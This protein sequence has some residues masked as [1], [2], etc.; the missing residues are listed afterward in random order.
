MLAGEFFREVF[1][2]A[3]GYVCIAM[4]HRKSGNKD[5]RET[6]YQ[7]PQQLQ[8]MH[9]AIEKSKYDR[10]IYFC[11]QLLTEPKR[12]KTS[13]ATATC[14]WCDLDTCNPDLLL[15]QPSIAIRTSPGRFQAFWRF[16][17]PQAPSVGEDI[18][19]RIAYR[20][21][22]DGADRSGWDLT[23]L[24]RVPGTR[25]FKYGEG[26]LAPPVEVV[27]QNDTRYRTDDFEVYP[28]AEGYEYTTIPMP[29]LLVEDG[30]KI[31]ERF[32]TRISG[33]AFTLFSQPVKEGDRSQALFRLEMLCAEAGMQ[34]EETFQVCR[35]S[36][37]NKWKEEPELLWRDICRA[38]AVHKD[39]QSLQQVRREDVRL[40]TEEERQFIEA[41]PTFIER[42]AAWGRTIG[43]AAHQYHRGAA[44]VALSAVLSGSIY[45]KAKFGKI[46]PN[47][48]LMILADTT[49]TR[50]ST[51][52]NAA[53]DIV[54]EVDETI[55]MATDGSLEG[56]TQALSERTGRTSIF[57][58]DEFTGLLESMMRKDYMAGLPE[59]F[60]ALYDGSTQIRRLRKD[61]IRIKSPRL[62]IFA[63]GIKSR[64][65]SIVTF[66]QV[67][68]GFLPRFI[69][70]TAE[71]D[72]TKMKPLSLA[73]EEEEEIDDELRDNLR[74]ELTD[75]YQHYKSRTQVP[76]TLDGKV[77]GVTSNMLR[78]RMSPDA[79]RRYNQ[80]EQ[81]LMEVGDKSGD[82][83]PIMMPLYSRLSVSMLKA[84]MLIAASRT[85]DD[86]VIV[87]EEDIIRAAY[88]GEE[89]RTYA[90]E[91]VV[92]VGKGPLEH[93]IELVAKAVHSKKRMAR[94]KLMQTYHLT[95]QEMST[96]ARTL[97]ERGQIT[98]TVRGREQIFQSSLNETERILHAN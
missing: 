40:V 91:V 47:L 68:S 78:V 81:T 54:N 97:D 88:Y 70:I 30:I 33:A 90:E 7:Y 77:V 9:Q 53:M 11:A 25:N 48:W 23:Q 12:T 32:S 10:D 46:V 61:E 20:H 64:M 42:Y 95:A 49:L 19:R 80:I 44:F 79:L 17:E 56:F 3:S 62:I 72:I 28:Q 94:S 5:Y 29:T 52:M 63:G 59:F 24:L 1:G 66:E 74:A 96:I 98:V 38:Y 69:F 89:W 43:D 45:L 14:A 22:D 67:T 21:A 37:C 31:L 76:M 85:R 34:A 27:V 92:D 39:T 50:K 35:D 4:I 51:A 2:T 65:Q 26:S 8:E 16:E 73:P 58:K 36:E 87:Q 60:T 13:V 18:S 57:L 75:I 84:A 15:V 71:T 55:L 83:R 6:F 82:M 41:N 93:K 86:R